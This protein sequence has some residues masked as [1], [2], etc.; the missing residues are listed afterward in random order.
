[1]QNGVEYIGCMVFARARHISFGLHVY[2][3]NSSR[4]R[5]NES[6]YHWFGCPDSFIT[7]LNNPL[8]EYI[9]G[10]SAYLAKLKCKY[11]SHEE[12]VN[13]WFHWI[14]DIRNKTYENFFWSIF[15]VY[16]SLSF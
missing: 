4:W 2:Q 11:A 3:K 5:H 15:L 10:E 9:P 8:N 14:K 13:S 1:M 7:I 12:D 16:V 6:E